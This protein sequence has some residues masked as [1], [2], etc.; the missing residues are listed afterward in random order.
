MLDSDNV[1]AVGEICARVDGLP[2]ALEL[3]AAQVR[4]LGVDQIRQRLDNSLELLADDTRHTPD[5]HKTLQAMLDWSRAGL[6][7]VQRL[8]FSGL[9][10]FAGGWT[11]EAAEAVCAGDGVAR[12]R[13]L[14]AVTQLVDKSLVTM[15][16]EHAA[17]RYRFLEPIRQYAR[18]K[19]LEEG[20][21]YSARRRRHAMY[22]CELAERLESMSRGARASTVNEERMRELANFQAAM[23]WA[24]ESGEQELGLRT[25][26]ALEDTWNFGRFTEGRDWL[27]QFLFVPGEPTRTRAKGLRAAGGIAFY[28]GDYSDAS[29]LLAESERLSRALGDE[30]GLADA[31]DR[32]ALV[33]WA[34]GALS[35]AREDL[36]ASHDLAH[37]HHAQYLEARILFHLGLVACDQGDLAQARM[38]HTRSLALAEE[39]HDVLYAARAYH[40]LARVARERGDA[41]LARTL[42]EAALDRR[43]QSGETW[44]KALELLELAQLNLE[45]GDS[46]RAREHL[47]ESLL[48]CRELGDRMLFARAF[49]GMAAVVAS[50]APAHAFQLVGAAAALREAAAAPLSARES[51]LLDR[52]M[53]LSRRTLGRERSLSAENAGRGMSIDDA[54]DLAMTLLTS[55]ATNRPTN[56]NHRVDNAGLTPR[57]MEILQFIAR[58]ASNKEIAVE[59]VLSV[60][61]VERHINN[62]YAKI[63]AHS[64]A[65]ATAYAFRTGL[66]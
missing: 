4:V 57:E 3:A 56:T 47:G 10:V 22:F 7:Q 40:G 60:R 65:E 48:L 17:A 39:L 6:D 44:G 54:I 45:D 58:G 5:R 8:F 37:R 41:S 16:E 30:H 53:A 36:I 32:V 42:F 55:E 46:Q 62:L 66:T 14:D 18:D 64:K 35:T 25:A 59:L 26:A 1:R 20:D 52:R 27:N 34:R 51:G 61:T 23:T 49:E 2:L 24:V 21:L 38:W 31:L 11:L 19:L 12:S 9:S 50:V 29:R 43:R 13:V 33:K 15:E 63:G 28:Q